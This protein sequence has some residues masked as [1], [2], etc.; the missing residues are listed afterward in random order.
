[1][2]ASATHI[3]FQK[4]PPSKLKKAWKAKGTKLYIK[5]LIKTLK[6]NTKEHKKS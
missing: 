4:P 6:S 5:Q 3:R 1:M 2:K